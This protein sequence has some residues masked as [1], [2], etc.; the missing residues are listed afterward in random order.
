MTV[1]FKSTGDVEP[2]PEKAGED[3]VA[4]NVATI[5]LLEQ[6]MERLETALSGVLENA[7]VSD[8]GPKGADVNTDV[9]AGRVDRMETAMSAKFNIIV[10]NIDKLDVQ[11][12]DLLNRVKT[13][14]KKRGMS[15]AGQG[16]SASLSSSGSAAR[17]ETSG[18]ARKA[19]G[20]KGTTGTSVQGSD[21][22]TALK[23]SSQTR[24]QKNNDGHLYHVVQK[25]ETFYSISR[26]YGTTVDHIHKLNHF[27]K[28]ADYLSRR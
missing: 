28:T 1:I 11:M 4:R 12:A 10:E 18:T 20:E 22:K 23:K 2:Q 19:A 16:A 3:P 15:S 21:K 17:T 6:R 27:T 8:G 7:S 5:T 24:D 13:L 26:K 14:E 9:L 25:G